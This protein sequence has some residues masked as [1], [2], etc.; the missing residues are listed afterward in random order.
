[1]AMDSAYLLIFV[2]LMIQDT[3]RQYIADNQLFAADARLLLAVSGGGD[4]MAMLD[5]LHHEGYYC[6]VAHVNFQLRGDASDRDEGLVTSVCHT[7][8]L[9]LHSMQIDTRLYAQ[10]HKQSI[11]MAAREIRYDF[12]E[13]LMDEHNLDCVVVAHHGDDVVETFFINLMRGTGLRGLSG[14]A[15]K[16]GRIV[17]PL[18]S[19]SH[20][21]LIGYL[22][23]RNLAYCTDA[24]NFDT[25]I[26]R[27]ELRH[28]II[29]SFENSKPGFS[30]V[31][32]R[33][34]T[35]LRQSEAVVK[36]YAQEWTQKHVKHQ[37]EELF[38]PKAE[39]YASVSASELL[40]H[41][42]QPMGFAIPI[43]DELSSHSDLRVGARFDALQHRLIVDRD[44][45]IVGLK[46]VENVSY[47]INKNSQSI[48]V[49][50]DMA[51]SLF[52]KDADFVLQRDKK[53]ALL[54]ADLLSFPLTLR[55]WQ[56][57]DV[58]CPIGM[59]GKQK[60]VSDYFIDQKFSI[61]EKEKAWLLC[62]GEDIVWIVGHRLDERYKVNEA[63]SSLFKI[64]L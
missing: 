63:S 14:I 27:N 43:I 45:L 24:T 52:S 31:M 36:A 54:D 8:G 47:T 33:T 48:K 11:E 62:S 20:Q 19:V 34:V 22:E 5:L 12:F 55:H 18:L 23:E 10:E 59:K 2:H 17:R 37:G 6:E 39:L 3:L 40:F 15:P 35:R 53:I 13:A 61:P 49:P 50:V 4:S 46:T 28:G 38:I 32:Q 42:L 30:T 29:P 7:K 26:L 21:D 60:K 1:M 44:F 9:V 56:E 25:T 41:I 57:G 51:I 64:E 16:N 58:F